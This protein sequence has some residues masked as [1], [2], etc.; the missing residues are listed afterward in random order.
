MNMHRRYRQTRAVPQG[1]SHRRDTEL[2]TQRPKLKP[3]QG[4]PIMVHIV[5]NIE[6]WPFDKPMPD[7]GNFSWVSNTGCAQAYRGSSASFRRAGCR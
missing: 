5:V 1:G 3:L 6:V 7:I 2:L 4:K